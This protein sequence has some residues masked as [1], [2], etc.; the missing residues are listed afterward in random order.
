MIILM[1]Q[2][3]FMMNMFMLIITMMLMLLLVVRA[4]G[5][6]GLNVPNLWRHE[7]WAHGHVKQI[8]DI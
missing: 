7:R 8:D 1:R 6:P 4:E 2:E 3:P 5:G